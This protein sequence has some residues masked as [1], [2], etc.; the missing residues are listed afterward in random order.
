MTL[1][2]FSLI[3]FFYY[4][5]TLLFLYCGLKK[6][7]F[8]IPSYY[9]HFRHHPRCCRGSNY[10]IVLYELLARARLVSSI[11]TILVLAAFRADIFL[12]SSVS[13]LFKTHDRRPS[14]IPSLLLSPLRRAVVYLAGGD[15]VLGC[16][17]VWRSP[18]PLA[19]FPRCPINTVQ[20]SSIIWAA[21]CCTST[22]YACAF[23][24]C[25]TASHPAMGHGIFDFLFDRWWWG[26]GAISLL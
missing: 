21:Q 14:F 4:Q 3:G 15:Y 11:T 12:H 16:L 24:H 9:Y 18:S 10:S 22:V 26:A 23:A 17:C 25:C 13:I 19:T 20:Y 8:C 1:L 5:T 2:L 6:S 7:S